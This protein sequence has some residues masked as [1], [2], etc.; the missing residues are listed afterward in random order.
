MTADEFSARKWCS[1][2]WPAQV[3]GLFVSDSASAEEPTT[4]SHR[5]TT[6]VLACGRMAHGYTFVDGRDGRRRTRTYIDEMSVMLVSFAALDWTRTSRVPC[7]SRLDVGDD[8]DGTTRN[9][10][11]SMRPCS[12]RRRRPGYNAQDDLPGPSAS[13]MSRRHVTRRA[14]SIRELLGRHQDD[15][16]RAETSILVSSMNRD[17]VILVNVA[18]TACG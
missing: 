13:R 12:S 6:L 15:G 9:L 7:S 16:R 4:S 2:S 1:H 8:D 5:T 10:E 18:P 17:P 3:C 14:H 11:M